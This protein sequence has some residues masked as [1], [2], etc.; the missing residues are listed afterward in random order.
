MLLMAKFSFQWQCRLVSALVVGLVVLGINSISSVPTPTNINS[1]VLNDHV[2]PDTTQAAVPTPPPTTIAEKETQQ[3]KKSE[4]V[5]TT[6]TAEPYTSVIP[7]V[8]HTIWKS[9]ILTNEAEECDR[10]WREHEPSFSHV[11]HDDEECLMLARRYAAERTTETPEARYL[12][13]SQRRLLSFNYTYNFSQVYENYQLNVMR[14]DVCRVLVIYYYGGFYMDLDVDFVR[15]VKDW[16]VARW[17]GTDILLGMEYGSPQRD[18]TNFFFAATARHPCMRILLEHLN[19]RGQDPNPFML[20]ERYVIHKHT[21]PT[22]W[23]Y[24]LKECRVPRDYLHTERTLYHEGGRTTQSVVG[25]YFY[26]APNVHLQLNY[27]NAKD[28]IGWFEPLPQLDREDLLGV[29]VKHKFASVNWKDGNYSSWTSKE[30][31]LKLQLTSGEPVDAL[32]ERARSPKSKYTRPQDPDEVHLSLIR[33]HRFVVWQDS[34]PMSGHALSTYNEW[35]ISEPHMTHQV[36]GADECLSLLR[37]VT[38][39]MLHKISDPLC[40]LLAVHML[41]GGFYMHHSV[42]RTG[43]FFDW[44]EGVWTGTDVLLVGDA[45]NAHLELFGASAQHRC[46][47]HAIENLLLQEKDELSG[48]KFWEAWRD[49]AVDDKYF[50]D[51]EER[52]W[53]VYGINKYHMGVK[54]EWLQSKGFPKSW[55]PKSYNA[56]GDSYTYQLQLRSSDLLSSVVRW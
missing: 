47:K 7:R 22:V 10:N 46:T 51:E 25:R 20:R 15:P 33:K 39:K 21:G 2:L 53:V 31:S 1:N 35:V 56:T 27:H 42:N 12:P 24:A 11:L 26:E 34:A 28:P 41:G 32:G 16:N 17:E 50:Q 54:L 23:L 8:R 55:L 19:R 13:L 40:G 4:E 36:V 9:K 29:L 14:A 38:T 52:K 37:M 5:S 48:G 18:L 49:C 30:A 43:S 44:S 6:P 45:P 3:A